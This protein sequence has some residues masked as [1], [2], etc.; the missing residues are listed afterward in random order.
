MSGIQ[1]IT[2]HADRTFGYDRMKKYV[3]PLFKK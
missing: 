2:K 1:K 3:N